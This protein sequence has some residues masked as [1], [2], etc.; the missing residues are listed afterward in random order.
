MQ[1]VFNTT[2]KLL[3]K[4]VK[5]IVFAVIL[6]FLIVLP[7]F[8]AD[9]ST[10]GMLQSSLDNMQQTEGWWD[11]LWKITFD[12]KQSLAGTGS[13]SDYVYSKISQYFIVLALLFWMGKFLFM[14]ASLVDRGP[15]H[16]FQ[17]AF[18]FLAGVVLIIL[19]M[20]NN[21]ERVKGICLDLRNIL[22][23]WPKTLMAAQISDS[24]VRSALTD[25]LVTD[26]AQLRISFYAQQCAPLMPKGI[27]PLPSTRPTDPAE[28]EKLSKAE[29]QGYAFTDCMKTLQAV[30]Q[31]ELA[32]ANSAC[33][34][35]FAPGGFGG[36]STPDTCSMLQ[37]FASKTTNTI[38]AVLKT[39]SDKLNS[40]Q[41][42]NYLFGQTAFLDFVA[43][44]GASAAFRPILNASQWLFISFLELALFLT[45]LSSLIMV[46]TALIPGRMNISIAWFIVF[47]TVGLAKLM[48]VVVMG[49]VALQ[50]SQD[51]TLLFSDMRFPMALAIAAPLVSLAAITV[52]GFAAASSFTGATLSV[53]SGAAVFISSAGGAISTALSRNSHSKR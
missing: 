7:S 39:E 16:V 27:S 37:R 6:A 9:D 48:Y 28:I 2:N 25:V 33:T 17:A 21:G 41:D 22:N 5:Y 52:G 29:Q 4:E 11:N 43:G 42:V 40:G 1:A 32:K 30:A 45:A 15:K 26:K 10:T 36:Q 12:S 13:L 19:L 49:S 20:A 14:A 23:S 51:Q 18:P 38:A 24:T 3:S 44:I 53:V 50:M 47:L 35:G 8:G 31:E 34:E 46:P